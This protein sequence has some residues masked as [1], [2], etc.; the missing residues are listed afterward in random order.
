MPWSDRVLADW[1][2]PTLWHLCIPRI[3]IRPGIRRCP[4]EETSGPEDKA[5]TQVWV[6]DGTQVFLLVL[7]YIGSSVKIKFEPRH[8][9]S[10]NVA[11]WHV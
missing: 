10:N 7:P 1:S 3:H 5:D 8:V 2:W 11:F 4:H 6:F 9:I